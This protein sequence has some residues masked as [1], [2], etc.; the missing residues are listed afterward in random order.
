[1]CIYIYRYV[2]YSYLNKTVSSQGVETPK[3]THFKYIN[4]PNIDQTIDIYIYIYIDPNAFGSKSPF[5]LAAQ[6]V[7]PPEG[8]HLR[9]KGLPEKPPNPKARGP[10][11]RH[12]KGGFF[13]I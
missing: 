6:Q 1:M 8:L 7:F 3:P 13:G 4:V 9:L 10:G 11:A 2:Y 12:E 5:A